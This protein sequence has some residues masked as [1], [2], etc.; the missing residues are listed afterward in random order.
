[1]S[2]REISLWFDTLPEPVR[3]RAPLEG[4]EDFD[5]AIVGAGYSG[6]WTAYYLAKLRPDL[7][8]AILEAEIAGFGASGRNGG[9]CIGLLAGIEGLLGRAE[10][11]AAGFALQRELFAAVDE[12]GRV[13]AAEGI[14]CHYRKGGSVRVAVTPAQE[15]ELRERARDLAELFSP[16]DFRWLDREECAERVRLH[17]GRG[18]VYTPHCA[19]IHPARLARGLATSVERLGVRIFERSPVERLEPGGLR[20]ARGAVSAPLIIRAT[21]AYTAELR[22]QRRAFLPLHSWMIATEPLPEG[23]WKEIGLAH[24]ETFGDGRRV[25][26][27]GQRTADD[28]LAF[29]GLATYRFGSRI[30]RH[31]PAAH[32]RF[33]E[34][35]GILHELLPA[36]R[37]VPITH[38]WGGALAV[39]RDWRPRVG[40][41]PARGLAWI[42][43]Y[44]GEGVAASNLAG[45]TLADLVAGVAS[46]RTRLAL[47]GQPARPWEPEPLRSLAVQSALGLAASAD[48]ASADGRRPTWRARLFRVVAGQ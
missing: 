11:R 26:T 10:R 42:G 31:F 13:A 37:G 38:R 32:P 18:G 20:T 29:G 17:G 44:V 43:G 47:V 14:D 28:R 15:R 3:P 21:E 27:Y 25:T 40:L 48:R 2:Y 34:L 46:E 7:R 4:I 35:E 8:I 6:L 36:L 9:W 23:L 22:G 19:A 1:M 16:E 33:A 12:V 5:V 30:A 39:P 45:R 24:A 41:D